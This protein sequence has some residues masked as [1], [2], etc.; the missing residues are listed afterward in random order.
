MAKRTERMEIERIVKAG[1]VEQA[2]F[3]KRI[4]RLYRRLGFR[5]LFYDRRELLLMVVMLL[6]GMPTLGFF[7]AEWVDSSPRNFGPL[8]VL[9][10]ISPGNFILYVS[11]FVLFRINQA[12]AAVEFTTRYNM[13]QLSALRFLLFSV[14]ALISMAVLIVCLAVQGAIIS[15]VH[16]VLVSFSSLFLFAFLY[17]AILTRLKP[18]WVQRW[19]FVLFWIIG[20]T[21]F[22]YTPFIPSEQLIGSIPIV[23]Y[24]VILFACIYGFYE[25]TKRLFDLTKRKGVL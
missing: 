3:Y 22:L 4:W 24:V 10:T 25:Q 2:P 6:V 5:Y 17:L 7:I 16:A 12:G 8:G 18:S 20:N 13:Y 15:I 19:G 1:M 11:A 14:V 21:V 23:V 9:F